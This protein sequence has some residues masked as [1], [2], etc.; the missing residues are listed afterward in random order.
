MT[1]EE[2]MSAIPKRQLHMLWP[3][4]HLNSPPTPVLPPAY[5]LRTFQSEDEDAYLNLMA[6]VGFDTFDHDSLKHWLMRVLPDGFFIIVHHPMNEIV[7]TA[8]ASHNPDPI[9]PFGGELGWV[10]ARVEH[11]GHGLGSVVCAA[12]TARFIKAGY[13]RIYLRTDDWRF[14]ALKTYLNLGYTPFIYGPEPQ[15][16]QARWKA[17]CDTLN[18]PFTPEAWPKHHLLDK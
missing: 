14:P 16:M 15:R 9:H 12:A 11:R 4:R 3:E 17:I 6:E 18:W 13:R 2:S 8:M 5:T 1:R 10:A 7:A